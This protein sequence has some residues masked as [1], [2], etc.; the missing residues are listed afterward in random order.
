MS[1]LWRNGMQHAARWAAYTVCTLAMVL[2]FGGTA[3][4]AALPEGL[5]DSSA[6]AARLKGFA[7]DRG[8]GASETQVNFALETIGQSVEGKPL[9]A[10]RVT[11]SARMAIRWKVLLI[12]AQH[13]DEHAGKEAILE[14]L[15]DL[16]SGEETLAAGVE[17]W[18]VPMANPD[19][20]DKD[21]RRNT[22]DVD[23]NRDHLILSQPETIA[24][25][26]LVQR[27]LPD[28]ILDCHE[29]T[30][31]SSSYTEQ[32]WGEWPL[33]M[34]DGANSPLLPGRVAGRLWNLSRAVSESMQDAGFNFMRYTVG[35]PPPHG[36][37]RFSTL[38][39]DDA[40]NALSFYGGLGVI[41]ESGI[42]RS[43]KDPQADLA[44]RVAAYRRLFELSL[45]PKGDVRQTTADQQ[46]A[47][48]VDPV[49]PAIVTNAF[50]SGD[51]SVIDY[52]VINRST[53]EAETVPAYNT[54]Y[55]LTIKRKVPT[56]AGYAVL[57]PQ[58]ERYAG[59]LE[60]HAV[61]FT[62]IERPQSVSGQTATL[63]RIE[64]AFDPI[65]ERYGG[66]Q[67]V[68]VEAAETLELP[69]GSIR[70]D[71]ATLQR[72]DVMAARRAIKVLE[73]Q[74]L[75]GLYQWPAWR[76]T[77]GEDGRIPVVRVMAE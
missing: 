59:L 49:G 36:E 69:E 52:P 75:Y 66:R 37:L 21:Q 19:G 30:R 67:I 71:L 9:L 60:K 18:A 32:G 65:Y 62:R 26:R 5:T 24:L 40:R 53:G 17:L 50:W 10:V 76:A 12:G 6:M 46:H 55:T 54:A 29:F 57:P 23:L 70:V 56:P 11:P 43:A 45:D 1:Y 22:N 39:P 51:R 25:H 15:A 73:P 68:S 28:L 63:V 47:M 31:D 14:L 61:P 48:A 42:K 44:L 3:S 77:I 35:G 16:G 2:T 72:S 64:E 38:D 33:I 34:W 4:R 20:V 7:D 41:V 8:E 58:A 74:Q 27:V 13:G